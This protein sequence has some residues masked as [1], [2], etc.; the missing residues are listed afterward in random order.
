MPAAQNMAVEVIHRLASVGFT[1]DDKAGAFFRAACFH[2]KFPGFEEKPPQKPRVPG[3]GFRDVRYVPFGDDKKMHRRLGR[4]VMEGEE[5][6]VFV[7][8]L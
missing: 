8:F 7:D 2:G 5:F 3:F 6:V 1:V 4:T